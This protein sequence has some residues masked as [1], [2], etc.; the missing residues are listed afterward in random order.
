[1]LPVHG[2][3]GGHGHDGQIQ[4][5]TLR[6][7]WYDASEVRT[8]RKIVPWMEDRQYYRDARR[9]SPLGGCSMVG[10]AVH[11]FG[12]RVVRMRH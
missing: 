4:T 5:Q 7:V 6:A 1:M 2:T 10:A 8:S 9:Q 11:R 12:I 3:S